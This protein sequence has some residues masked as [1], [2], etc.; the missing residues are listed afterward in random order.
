MASTGFI[1]AAILA[2]IMPEI[3]PNTIH[4]LSAIKIILGAMVIGNGRTE[5]KPKVNNQTKKNDRKYKRLGKCS[6][7]THEIIC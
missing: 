3:T 6:P 5:L 1:F 7:F 2:G 4:K